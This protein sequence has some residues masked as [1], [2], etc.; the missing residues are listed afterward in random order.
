MYD[1]A[2]EIRHR[3]DAFPDPVTVLAHSY[4]GIPATQAAVG[5]PNVE[6]LVHVSAFQLDEGDSLA[7]L[8]GGRVPAGTSGTLTPHED[9]HRFFYT[10]VTQE[11]A[12]DAAAARLVLQ[13]LTSFNEPLTG[14][15]WKDIPSTYVV[16][17]KDQAIPPQLQEAM[18]E[19]STQKYRLP[20]SHSPFL[21][22]PAELARIVTAH[23]A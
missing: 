19:R 18:A 5:A 6:R 15:A 21:S 10:D 23:N 20:S 4:G 7:S 16:C 12:D 2:R 13:T 3:I 17:E 9:P 22:M 14:A 8:S 11:V 1:D